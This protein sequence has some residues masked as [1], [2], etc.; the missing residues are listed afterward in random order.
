MRQMQWAVAAVTLLLMSGQSA[1]AYWCGGPGST[2]ETQHHVGEHSCYELFFNASGGALT[3][4]SV[5]VT[6]LGSATGVNE[7]V[8]STL[9]TVPTS[10]GRNAIDVDGTDGDV[11]NIGTY[12]TTTTSADLERVVGVIDDDSCADATYCRVQIYGPRLTI[13]AGDTDNITDGDAV[14]TTTVAG[15]AGD[16]ANDADGILGFAMSANA[17]AIAADGEL[18]WVFIRPVTGE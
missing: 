4:G 15:M 5:V 17:A 1:L 13:I 14:G 7:G 8:G 11:T 12:I 2:G 6:A 3:S 9:D 18:Q 10:A 16:A